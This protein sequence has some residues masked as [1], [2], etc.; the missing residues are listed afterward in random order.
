MTYRKSSFPA[1]LRL[2]IKS[3]RRTAL[4]QELQKETLPGNGRAKIQY[5]FP[6]LALSKSGSRSKFAI[7]SQPVYKLPVVYMNHL[8]ALILT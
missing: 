5:Y 4:I 3:R 7:S 6:T 2:L 8:T 1:V